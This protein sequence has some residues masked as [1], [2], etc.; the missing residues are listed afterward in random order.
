MPLL[1][2]NFFTL[3]MASFRVMLLRSTREESIKERTN[4]GTISR[5]TLFPSLRTLNK[6]RNL[7]LMI[8]CS[9]FGTSLQA[10]IDYNIIYSKGRDSV[11]LPFFFPLKSLI[12]LKTLKS[13]LSLHHLHSSTV[14]IHAC[15]EASSV[16]IFSTS[17]FLL[18]RNS[19]T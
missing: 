14:F 1:L 3:F 12:S 18:R 19:I 10:D 15:S 6:W 2:I 17:M 4:I 8:T 16:L 7:T 9:V 11:S 5:N 13:L